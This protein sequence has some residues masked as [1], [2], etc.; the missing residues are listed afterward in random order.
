MIIKYRIYD[1][2]YYNDL[3][4]IT[5]NSFELTSFN[6]D[7]RIPAHKAGEI[8]WEIWCNPVLQSSKKKYCIVATVDDKAV[9]YIIYGANAEFSKLLNM[10]IGCIILTA[11]DKNYRTKYKIA[12][13][14]LKY[15]ITQY[16]NLKMDM[17]SVGTDLDNL[18]AIINYINNGFRPILQ[19]ST[20]RYYFDEMDIIPNPDIQIIQTNKFNA[21]TFSPLTRPISLLLD[22]NISSDKKNK[23]IKHVK[24]KVKNDITGNKLLSYHIKY[25]KRHAAFV[26][27]KHEKSIS[28]ILNKPFFRIYDFYVID[29]NTDFN[30]EILSY[31]FKYLKNEHPEMEIIEIFTSL[32]NWDL[33][34][35]LS[36]CG[37]ILVHNAVTL[38]YHLVKNFITAS[39]I[40]SV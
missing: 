26:T 24:K 6:T 33:I 7:K 11:V 4:T 3:K 40:S 12:H 9:G 22:N 15:T 39:Q 25:K 5:F 34:E 16:K 32:N 31:F 2:K 18:P 14:L 20:F 38:H 37:F 17:I 29:K 30:K 8:A 28:R 19:W 36:K 27:L 1:D 10:K 23:L 21:K 35:L 13:N